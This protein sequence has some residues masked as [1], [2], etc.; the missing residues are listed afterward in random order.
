ME[1]NSN[2]R[3]LADF[4]KAVFDGFILKKGYLYGVDNKGNP[5]AT[6]TCVK[7]GSL[8]VYTKELGAWI[9][10][11]VPLDK[12]RKD[13]PQLYKMLNLQQIKEDR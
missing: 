8:A 4:S 6:S 7:D 10:T 12:V 1:T 2:I 9:L 3:K 5:V 11:W 13:Y